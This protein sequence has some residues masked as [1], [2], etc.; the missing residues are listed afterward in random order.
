[1][2]SQQRHFDAAE[3]PHERE[4]R[5]QRIAPPIDIAPQPLDGERIG[6]E[7]MV[8]E[9]VLDHRHDRFRREGRSINLAYAFDAG[10]VTSLRKR[11]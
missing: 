3:N 8:L 9:H 6:A 4:I 11:K 1:M 7:H 10:P 5:P 2:M